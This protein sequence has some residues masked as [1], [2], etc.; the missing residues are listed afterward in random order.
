LQHP[1][2]T[3]AITE[4]EASRPDRGLRADAQR[5][6]E[7]LLAVARAA[8][9]RAQ[10][11]VPLE[12]IARDAGVGIG[13][14]YRHFPTRE[15]LVEAVYGAE[16]DDVTASAVT[17]LAELPADEALRVWVGRYADFVATKRGMADTLRAGWASGRIT[18]PTTRQRI[19]ASIAI[20]LEAGVEAG[21]IRSD[22]EP[23]DVTAMLLGVFLSTAPAADFAQSRRLLDLVVDAV[24]AHP[25]T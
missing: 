13:T 19:T 25:N 24:R 18:T 17:L 3:L 22:I 8:F 1:D 11:V 14:L 23:E 6:R 4:L 2:P 20:L 5:N 15:S 16:L 12:T 9:S 21:Q 10:E 7:R